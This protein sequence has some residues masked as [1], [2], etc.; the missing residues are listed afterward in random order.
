MLQAEEYQSH[1][2]VRR[3]AQ[4]KGLQK[5]LHLTSQGQANEPMHC[6][7]SSCVA[8]GTV[9]REEGTVGLRKLNT[10]VHYSTGHLAKK[11]KKLSQDDV[12]ARFNINNS[13]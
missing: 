10:T 1:R 7:S 11:K 9:S 5:E 6:K 3:G 2:L 8:E 12:L 13:N 4:R